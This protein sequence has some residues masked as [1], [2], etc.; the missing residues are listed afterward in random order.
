MNDV[1]YYVCY[2]CPGYYHMTTNYKKVYCLLY[3][4]YPLHCYIMLL[5]LYLYL[6]NSNCCYMHYYMDMICY[7]YPIHMSMVLL[8][9]NFYHS[10]LCYIEVFALDLHHKNSM[11]SMTNLNLVSNSHL[12]LWLELLECYCYHICLDSLCILMM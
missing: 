10:L 3:C 11:H 5:D 1:G 8:I 6:C 2:G 12:L 9:R 4:L 7:R